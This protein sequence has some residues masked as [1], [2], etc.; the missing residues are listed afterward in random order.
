MLAPQSRLQPQCLE[1]SSPGKLN[2]HRV[3]L[4]ILA[5]A[6]VLRGLCAILFN[7]EIDPEGAEY[8]R[9]AENILLGRGYVGIATEGVQLFFPPLFP[10]LFPLLIAGIS[11]LIGDPETAGRTL[12]VF[13][14][15]LLVLPVY[16]IARRLFDGNVGLG[17]AALV[18]VHPYLVNL[19][20]TVYCEPT[21]LT[22]LLSA[23]FAAMAAFAFKPR[24]DARLGAEQ[25]YAAYRI[26]GLLLEE[27]E[28]PRYLRIAHVQHLMAEGI[29]APDLRHRRRLAR[30]PRP[31]AAE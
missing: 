30:A 1:A 3:L 2:G 5:T 22:L 29:L 28:G 13:F 17:A 31:R 27:F 8:A 21:Y 7:G 11:M 23:V 16:G 9:I 12:N 10:P 15:A 26:A 6:L 4:L 24:W 14:G 19:S 25:L 20:T 18:A